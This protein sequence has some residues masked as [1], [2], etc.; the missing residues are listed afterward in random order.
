MSTITIS[1]KEYQD[2]VEKKLR[3]DYLR[4]MLAADVFSAPPTRS[5]KTVLAAFK[6]TKRYNKKFLESLG[7]GLER[8]SYFR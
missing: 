3:Y 8:S 2:L 5:R 7:K 4:Q 6:A 1:K